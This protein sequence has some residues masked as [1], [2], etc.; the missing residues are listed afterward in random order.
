MIPIDGPLALSAKFY[1]K[2]PK[3]RYRGKDGSAALLCDKRPD[4]DNLAKAILDGLNGVAFKD[5]GQV[6]FMELQKFYHETDQAQRT[7]IEIV[8]A[9]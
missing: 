8:S 6:C 7:E 4:L 2:R 1:L 5:D 9:R 3:N